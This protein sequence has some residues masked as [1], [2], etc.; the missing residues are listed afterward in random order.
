LS[1]NV[2]DHKLTKEEK[3]YA[4][5][6]VHYAVGTGSAAVYGAAA[7]LYPSV[8]AG[9]GMPF[10]AAVW[11]VVDEG[12]VP[13]LGLSKTPL[14]YPASTHIYALASHLVYGL[15]AEFV[16]RTVRQALH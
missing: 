5:P 14:E 12:A 13:A 1:E 7:E 8:T 10:G 15:S 2:F 3:E 4:G 9:A 11:L 16:R 6:A